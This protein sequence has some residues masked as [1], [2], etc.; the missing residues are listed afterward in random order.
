MKH[1]VI[2]THEYPTNALQY[3]TRIVAYTPVCA[4]YLV[5]CA[6]LSIHVR[7]FDSDCRR[8][9]W[10]TSCLQVTAP[11]IIILPKGVSTTASGAGGVS[12]VQAHALTSCS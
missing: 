1:S 12:M 7:S 8:S 4:C 3:P 5:C 6:T 11:G 2:H 9:A 10:K